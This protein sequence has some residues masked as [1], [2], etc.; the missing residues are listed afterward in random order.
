M[1]QL[2][3]DNHA[4]RRTQTETDEKM[5]RHIGGDDE[6]RRTIG[7]LV[8]DRSDQKQWNSWCQ[9]AASFT[10]LFLVPLHWSHSSNLKTC[11]PKEHQ[12]ESA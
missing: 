6:A 2:R 10:T 8:Q 3:G 12:T 4:E 9:L 5:D 11:S 7:K 1:E